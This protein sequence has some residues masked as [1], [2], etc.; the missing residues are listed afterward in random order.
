MMGWDCNPIPF[1]KITQ[2]EKKLWTLKQSNKKDEPFGLEGYDAD[3]DLALANGMHSVNIA[4]GPF[5]VDGEDEVRFISRWT[6]L[7]A[8]AAIGKLIRPN[9]MP[10]RDFS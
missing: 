4:Y 8:K 3:I 5:P 7:V 10:I 9:Y 6:D 2:K 1:P